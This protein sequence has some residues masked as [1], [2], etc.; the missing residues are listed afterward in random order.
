MAN[1]T[2][3]FALHP[4]AR[5]RNGMLFCPLVPRVLYREITGR[6]PEPTSLGQPG[7]SLERL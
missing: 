6:V 5:L 3:R 2:G 1:I 4:R 7:G